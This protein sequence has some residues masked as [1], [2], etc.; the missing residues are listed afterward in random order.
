MLVQYY[1]DYMSIENRGWAT[2]LLHK[3]DNN[4]GHFSA[5][6]IMGVFSDDKVARTMDFFGFAARLHLPTKI[7]PSRGNMKQASSCPNQSPPLP[8][9]TFA[10]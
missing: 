10:S 7:T 8:L 6:D 9:L 4:P 5:R 1:T 3:F 2:L